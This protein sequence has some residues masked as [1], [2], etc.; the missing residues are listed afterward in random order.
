[1]RPVGVTQRSAAASPGWGGRRYCCAK[2][3]DRTNVEKN[4]ALTLHHT[5]Q[6]KT[7]TGLGRV[8]E[9]VCHL[10][11]EDRM[12]ESNKPEGHRI[13][14]Q[15]PRWAHFPSAAAAGVRS[16]IR[17]RDTPELS[18]SGRIQCLQSGFISSWDHPFIWTPFEWRRFYRT[19]C[20]VK[21]ESKHKSCHHL[22]FVLDCLLKVLDG[23][24]PIFSWTL[25]YKRVTVFKKANMAPEWCHWFPE[26][27]WEIVHTHFKLVFQLFHLFLRSEQS[28]WRV[29]LLS[30]ALLWYL[31][32]SFFSWLL[33]GKRLSVIPLPAQQN[34][35]APF[36]G[37]LRQICE[38]EW[39]DAVTERRSAE[40]QQ[41]E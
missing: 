22:M 2:G 1:M 8:S 20:F 29:T 19:G 12:F 33:T 38:G 39:D 11:M 30:E 18:E 36:V 35:M 28:V 16:L 7:P 14:P 26:S 6:R 4:P 9:R 25:S 27:E 17:W 24:F 15:H 21:M 13:P 41:Q 32:C 40:Q 3:A 5:C 34:M 23:M 37:L 31:L 10:R